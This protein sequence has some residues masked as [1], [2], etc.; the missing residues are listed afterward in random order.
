MSRVTRF[1]TK[2]QWLFVGNFTQYE[3]VIRIILHMHKNNKSRQTEMIFSCC[4]KIQLLHHNFIQTHKEVL[5]K[6]YI[7]C[8]CCCC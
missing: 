6:M 5:A 2:P 7:C 4:M 1:P 8:D 3:D